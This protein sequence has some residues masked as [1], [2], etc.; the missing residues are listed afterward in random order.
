MALLILLFTAACAFGADDA[1]SDI[2][3][4]QFEIGTC[5]SFDGRYAYDPKI[6]KCKEYIYSG[7]GGNANNFPTEE[8]CEKATRVCRERDV[9]RREGFQEANLALTAWGGTSSLCIWLAILQLLGR[10]LH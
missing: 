4:M 8:E 5:D 10:F 3:R 1:V 7:C 6:G 2:C 9:R